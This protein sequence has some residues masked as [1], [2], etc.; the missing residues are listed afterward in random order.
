MREWEKINEQPLQT[1]GSV[2]KESGRKRYPFIEVISPL[3]YASD[4]VIQLL[5]D[6]WGIKPFEAYDR[7]HSFSNRL[8]KNRS[9]F[10]LE[11]EVKF[12]VEKMREEASVLKDFLQGS[13]ALHQ[14]GTETAKLCAEVNK[15]L[16]RMNERDYNLYIYIIDTLADAEVLPTP[17]LI[18]AVMTNIDTE[19]ESF[20]F[21]SVLEKWI[22]K[23]SGDPPLVILDTKGLG[24]INT[25]EDESNFAQEFA[26]IFG[27]HIF[28]IN[29][30]KGDGEKLLMPEYCIPKTGVI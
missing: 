23:N 7:E 30:E 25:K 22:N 24:F 9:D 19:D 21:E 11:P 15:E 17:D 10:R 18:V 8:G 26:N 12:L 5:T 16:G 6:G 20:T 28:R 29:E 27:Y 14:Q 4:R 13:L 2:P 3:P 1:E